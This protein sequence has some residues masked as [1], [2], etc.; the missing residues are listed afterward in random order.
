M[1]A[2]PRRL[3]FRE[4]QNWRVTCPSQIRKF[5]NE[6]TSTNN[7]SLQVSG[8]KHILKMFVFSTMVLKFHKKNPTYKIPMFTISESI[9]SWMDL[10]TSKSILSPP[11]TPKHRT[12][13]SHGHTQAFRGH[14]QWN[15][16]RRPDVSE[17]ATMSFLEHSKIGL[18]RYRFS[19]P[20]I[21][22]S[23]EIMDEMIN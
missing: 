10:A 20:L 13:C 9:Y 15:T 8:E 3:L 5:P 18:L 17:I 14:R 2:G 12:C 22:N 19:A 1:G 23:K 6:I 4:C 21:K 11:K 16:Q 7:Q